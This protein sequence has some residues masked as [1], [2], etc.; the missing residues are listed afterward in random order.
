MNC[1]LTPKLDDMT[2]PTISNVCEWVIVDF[3]KQRFQG[4]P[5][6][7]SNIAKIQH[8]LFQH[9]VQKWDHAFV[10]GWVTIIQFLVFPKGI[11]NSTNPDCNSTCT[12]KN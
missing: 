1:V 6:F 4:Q 5:S 10:T 11:L 3:V 2:L 9:D 8:I 7:I 12:D